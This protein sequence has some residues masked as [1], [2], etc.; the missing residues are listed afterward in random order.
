MKTSSIIAVTA[1]YVALLGWQTRAVS[2]AECTAEDFTFQSKLMSTPEFV[3]ACGQATMTVS[4]QY[5]FCADEKCYNY[6]KSLS[7]ELPNCTIRGAPWRKGWDDALETCKLKFGQ[8]SSTPASGGKNGTSSITTPS[9]A[10][11][12]TATRSSD[13]VSMTSASM[14]VVATVALTA[15]LG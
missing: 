7:D 1:V 2:A 11:V 15:T 13:A 6:V 9:E 12:P 4:N 5:A 10:P 3:K 8:G 14:A